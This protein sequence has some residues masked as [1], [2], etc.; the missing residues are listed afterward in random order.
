[1]VEIGDATAIYERPTAEY[2]RELI[3][4]IR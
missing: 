3:G 1:V 4:A 2:T